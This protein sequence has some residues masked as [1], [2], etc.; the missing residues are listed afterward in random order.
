MIIV[1]GIEATAACYKQ[2]LICRA[3]FNNNYY[4]DPIDE[5]YS[6]LFHSPLSLCHSWLAH[7]RELGTF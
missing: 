7:D 3:M 6:S 4:Y 1:D 5:G 2:K